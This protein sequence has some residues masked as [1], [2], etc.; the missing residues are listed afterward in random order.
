[1]RT[2]KTIGSVICLVAALVAVIY[3]FKMSSFMP[4]I[5]ASLFLVPIRW[6][7]P[8]WFKAAWIVPV[9]GFL[10]LVVD[11][12]AL[13]HRIAVEARVWH[14]VWDI[15]YVSETFVSPSGQTTVYLL[16]S[17]WLDLS[18]SVCVSAGGLFPL[19][20]YVFS[21]RTETPR[22]DLIVG[23]HGT[24]F[25]IGDKLISYAYSE[26]DQR[27]Y[28]YD[29][30]IRGPIEIDDTTKTLEGFSAYITSLQAKE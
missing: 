27:A 30:W 9:G 12:Y 24:L 5:L 14:P 18:Y 7:R 10:L 25:S 22:R 1:M 8:S 28:T 3:Q 29:E 16:T 2:I 20:G 4:L 23:W 13:R 15:T 17:S 26:T 11:A 6:L 19:E 21:S